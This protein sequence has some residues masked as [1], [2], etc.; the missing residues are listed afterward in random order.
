[1]NRI[2]ISRE[3]HIGPT[4]RAAYLAWIT[5]AIL[6]WVAYNQSAAHWGA[7]LADAH[8]F[9]YFGW[10]VTQGERPYLDFWD[11]KP[12]GIW[13]LNAAAFRV[14]GEGILGD[15]AICGAATFAVIAAVRAIAVATWEMSLAWP[16]LLVGGMLLTH[17]RF[18]CGVN[19]TETFV[20]AFESAAVA[21]FLRSRRAQRQ[22]GWLAA[23]GICAGLAPLFKQ[24]GAAAG[25]AC[26]CGLTIDAIAARRSTAQRS[27]RQ[28]LLGIGVFCTAALMPP[29]A[30]ALALAWPSALGAAYF[31]TVEFN[32]AYFA[33]GDASWMNISG[34]TKLFWG[35][36]I[37]P[38]AW[39]L[40]MG[41]AGAL[42]ALIRR[43]Q[44][45]NTSGDPVSLITVTVWGG[46]AYY[47]ATVGPGR[48]AY[49][50]ATVLPAIAVLSLW[51]LSVLARSGN[52]GS[53]IMRRPSAAVMLVIYTAGF[54][55]LAYQSFSAARG[56][57]ASKP[58]WYSLKRT[59]P[60]GF[61]QQAMAIR[62]HSSPADRVYVWG[63]DP[64]AYRFAYRRTVSRFVTLEKGSHVGA[65][66]RFIVEGAIRDLRATPPRVFMIGTAD[67]RGLQTGSDADFAVFITQNYREISTIDGMML[68][69][70]ELDRSDDG[71]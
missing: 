27:G 55:G 49:H 57:W 24:A 9:G 14:F 62:A 36:C 61:E 71:S 60:S 34:G 52:L 35:K 67:W 17:G 47:L 16:A 50:F 66:A 48:Q 26:L 70:L 18:E 63:W 6:T 19:R 29:L 23:A 56:A 68:F 51:P 8:L 13:W 39:P 21:F 32:R 37:V 30:A 46:I 44:R 64:G 3:N 41:A 59:H 45:E 53:A 25:A 38:L 4:A 31:A 69:V 28:R 58:H 5:A 42:L 1:M 12:P 54:S 40:G 10:L 15:M 7:N 33:V 65:H 11:N 22:A 43:F 20:I 2:V